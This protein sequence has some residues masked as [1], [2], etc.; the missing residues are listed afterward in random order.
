MTALYTGH[1][2]TIPDPADA[3]W[4]I[5]DFLDEIE[6]YGVIPDDEFPAYHLAFGTA[7]GAGYAS[8]WPGYLFGGRGGKFTLTR[9]VDNPYTFVPPPPE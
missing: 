6:N 1:G 3:V 5:D 8:D 9:H 2:R 7:F 4:D